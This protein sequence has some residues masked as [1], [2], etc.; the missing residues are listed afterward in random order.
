MLELSCSQCD[1]V[2]LRTPAS[3]KQSKSG[4]VFCS[5]SCSASYNN[6]KHPK[7]GKTDYKCEVCGS[8][9]SKK[10]TKMCRDC[11]LKPKT[12]N[13]EQ[14]EK[15]KKAR[16]E[17]VVR[18]TR[19]RKLMYVEYLGGSCVSCGY[20][21]VP[22]S[23]VFH[24]R[25]PSE[26]EFQLAHGNVSW[27]R[28]VKELDKCD[29]LCVNCHEEVHEIPIN[30]VSYSSKYRRRIKKQCVNYLGGSC[31]VCGY[32]GVALHFHH[33]N[34]KDKKFALSRKSGNFE[35]LRPELDKCILLCGNCHFEKH[36]Q[37]YNK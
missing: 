31:S 23:L 35:T 13:D 4:N 36:T 27:E 5:R 9:V 2:V 11:F 20:N 1:K 16:S 33:K 25:D 24:H 15:R 3:Y 19:R 34:P 37:M 29:L 30:L 6:I 21:A 32:S 28:A 12:I 8:K 14:L 10:T 18:H 7:R 22:W 17:A 26:K